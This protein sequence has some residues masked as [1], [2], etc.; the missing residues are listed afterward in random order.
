MEKESKIFDNY[1][2]DCNTCESYWNSQC[3][4]VKVNDRRNCTSYKATRNV[5]VVEEI[6]NMKTTIERLDKWLF[7]TNLTLLLMVIR[8]VFA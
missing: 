3:D 1:E 8:V 2:V 5:D 4:G 7:A 6:A